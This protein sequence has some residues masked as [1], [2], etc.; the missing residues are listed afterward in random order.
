MDLAI[1]MMGTNQRVSYMVKHT[2]YSGDEITWCVG[3]CGY[4]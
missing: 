4:A 1:S 3:S 2:P